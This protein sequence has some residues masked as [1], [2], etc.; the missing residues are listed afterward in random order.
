[1]DRSAVILAGG[2]S[3]RFG[4]DKGLIKLCGKPLIQHVI[5]AVNS[6]VDEIIVVTNSQEKA[7][8][9]ANILHARANFAVDV[10]QSKGPLGGAIAGFE[11]AYGEYTVLLPFDTPFVQKTI[12]QLLFDLC[13]NKNAV[14]PRWP[15]QNIEPLQS[16]YRTKP[17]VAAARNALET[18]Q[19][20]MRAMIEKLH[21][22]RYVSTLVLQQFD[23]NLKTLFNINTPEDLKKAEALAKSTKQ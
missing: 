5:D 10:V 1:V 22:V 21:N 9:Y 13:V 4:Q 16:V 8:E 18:G 14:I 19:N 12:L 23:P 6:I 3:T 20:T 11:S 7:A 17:A 2:H 15:N